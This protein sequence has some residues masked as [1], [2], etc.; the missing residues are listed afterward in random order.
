M[1]ST[2]REEMPANQVMALFAWTTSVID[3]LGCRRQFT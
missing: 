1:Q 3:T 2:H